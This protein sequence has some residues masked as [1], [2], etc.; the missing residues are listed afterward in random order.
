MFGVYSCLPEDSYRLNW[1]IAGTTMI[2]AI[3]YT[4]LF[5]QPLNSQLVETEKCISVK[6]I[7]SLQESETSQ[8]VNVNA[9][10]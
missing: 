8:D 2:S 7:S 3:P 5:I 9:E 6:G 1:L 10:L 4:F